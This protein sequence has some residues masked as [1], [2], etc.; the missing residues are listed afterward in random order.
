MTSLSR[1]LKGHTMQK[2]K[3]HMHPRPQ[4]TRSHWI[5]LT[6]TWNFTYDD[7]DRGLNE[8]W[9]ERTDVYT[10][11]I[12]VPFPP[13]SSASGISDNSFHPILWYQ[14]TFQV[15][16]EYAGKRLILHCGAVDYRARVWVNGQLVATHE[17]GN[18]PFSADITPV[19]RADR[20]QVIVIRAEDMPEDL[21]QPRGKQD[22][23]E[24]PHAIWYP[25][26]SG[27]WQ[28][29]WLEPVAETHIIQ[30]RW[31][32]DLNRGVLAM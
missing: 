20:E 23:R 19:L 17:G 12:Q 32:P 14:R 7:T 1:I 11:T 16:Q 30:V 21:A 8:G 10:R 18:T 27:I 28:P 22:W 31:T 13:E 5:D 24:R 2:Q 3:E 9:Q 6:G 4:L 29:V 25:R 26:T 15:P